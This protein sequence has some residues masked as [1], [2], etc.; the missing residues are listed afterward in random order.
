[1]STTYGTGSGYWESP[2]PVDARS[3][4]NASPEA[5]K[6]A[7]AVLVGMSAQRKPKSGAEIRRTSGKR[8]KLRGR[9]Y[10]LRNPIEK[11]ELE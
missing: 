6:T 10:K 8:V 4:K 2:E 9:S 1:M 11:Q 3:F 5:L 7:D